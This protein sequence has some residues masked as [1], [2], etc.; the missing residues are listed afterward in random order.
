MSGLCVEKGAKIIPP[1]FK[2]F[3][4]LLSYSLL[5]FPST[6]LSI[7]QS[8][9]LLSTYLPVCLSVFLS[10]CLYVWLSIYLSLFISFFLLSI[11]LAAF[12]NL[13]SDGPILSALNGNFQKQL[14]GV[15]SGTNP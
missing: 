9:D 11:S 5:L 7:F 3:S 6:Y 1:D 2:H 13:I 12:L 10:V 15:E 14:T 4:L 8:T